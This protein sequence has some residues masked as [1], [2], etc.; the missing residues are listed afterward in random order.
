VSSDTFGVSV[1]YG[2]ASISGG[3][4]SSDSYGLV[5]FG[6]TASISGGSV[7]G[8]YGV[9]VEGGTVSLSGGSIS[10]STFGV[11]VQISGTLTVVGCNLT[12]LRLSESFQL[13]GTLT[14]GSLINTVAQVVS[15]GQLL[16]TAAYTW[17]GVLPP[18][19]ADG[20]SV[21]KA[22]SIVPVRFAL[23]GACA[24]SQVATL[25]YR[26]VRSNV[27]GGVNEAVSTEAATSGN[28]FRYTGGQYQ[29]NWSTK[30]LPPGTYE[31]QIDLGNGEVHS[32]SLGLR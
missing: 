23:T 4:V 2:T 14:D 6:G 8:E 21:F 31:L 30:G 10:G 26:Q 11:Y 17:A 20:T 1:Y 3:S 5:V 19:N 9:Y 28:Q 18:I 32:V 22:G 12:Q 16:L 27:A 29:F 24:G 25:A 15:P 7:S 13:T